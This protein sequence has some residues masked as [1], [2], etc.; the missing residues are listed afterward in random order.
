MEKQLPVSVWHEW[1]I[2]EKIGEG[3]FGKVYKAQR[4]EQGKVFYSAIK[5]I[6]IPSSQGELSSVRSENPDEQSVKEYFHS[7][8]EDCIQEVS[9]MEYFR[10]NSHVVSVEDYKVVEYLDDI[11]WDIYIR[12]EYLTSFMDYCAGKELTE[13][14]VIR[15]GIDLCKALEYCQK[16]NIIHRDIKPENIFVSRFGEFK[17][18]DFGIARELD[19]NASGLSKKGTF[20]YMAPEMYKGESYDCRVD[21]YSLGIVMYRL[22]NRNRLP[23]INLGK[24]LITYRDKEN[25]LNRR[26]AG[27]ELS[28]PVEAG[29]GLSGVILKACAY[30]RE[31]RYQTAEEFRQAL[32]QAASGHIP[33]SAA[34]TPKEEKISGDRKESERKESVRLSKNST[35]G[36][37]SQNGQALRSGGRAARSAGKKPDERRK[38]VSRGQKRPFDPLIAAIAVMGVAVCVIV[39]VFIWLVRENAELQRLK[40]SVTETMES[41]ENKQLQS[42]LET[43]RERAT[44][45]TEN[46]NNYNWIGSEQE[47]KISY[48]K[49]DGSDTELM[50]VL[51][52]PSLSGDGYY[53]EFYYWNGELFFA[54]IWADRSTIPELKEGEQ[55]ANLYY[56]D[57]GKL[58]RWIDENNICHD[59]ETD[60]EEYNERGEKYWNLAEQYERELNVGNMSEAADGMQETEDA[61]VEEP[62][63]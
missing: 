37:T 46:L 34:E 36:Q 49:T 41:A 15:L 33:E 10:G 8:V 31:K 54:Y 6:T 57:D 18:G 50:K 24:Q 35:D 7:L 42:D 63:S 28:P 4:T 51:V 38:R 11:G 2:I 30:D 14:E 26:M 55:R 32:E 56:Y 5:I 25:A 47:G 29:E 40:Q 12:M 44:E 22:R 16:Q 53:E 17:L 23:F 13:A 39:G 9:T 3:S 45:I 52:Y 20:S 43:I 48:L 58:I 62:A 1:K 19:R 27:E 59:G 21:I 60:N 61:P